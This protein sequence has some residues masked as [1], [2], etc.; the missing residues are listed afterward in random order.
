[1]VRLVAWVIKFKMILPTRIRKTSNSAREELK[2]GR[3]TVSLL[4]E[5]RKLIV[6]WYRQKAFSEEI[7]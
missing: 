3:L 2:Q 5:A 1:M 7:E 6:R 4:D